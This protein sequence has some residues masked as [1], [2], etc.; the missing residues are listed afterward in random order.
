MADIPTYEIY[1]LQ[2]GRHADRCRRQNLLVYDPRNDAMPMDFF[3]WL[4][5]SAQRTFLVD[6]GYTGATAQARNR[7]VSCC[8][9]EALSCL[10]VNA[11][12]ITDVILTHMHW[13]HS[14]NINQLPQAT[15]HIQEAEMEYA[16][17]RYMCQPSLR[18]A[19]SG[20]DVAELVRCVHQGRVKFYRGDSVMAPGVELLYIGGHSPG[21]QVVRVFTKRGWVVVASDAV[22]YYENLRSQNPFPI[23]FH[24]GDVLAGYETLIANAESPEHIVPGHDPEVL[25][26]YPRFQDPHAAIACL[27]MAPV[28]R[29]AG[30]GAA[31]NP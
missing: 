27:H 14:G 7:P 10:G 1:A 17:G 24:V 28:Q 11:A 5:K 6:T 13:D 3:V 9:M 18:H 25:R 20:E 4:I 21:L 30:V 16:T 31:T 26:I 19:Y 2:Y 23:L 15:F 12:Q 22:H 29:A 8:P